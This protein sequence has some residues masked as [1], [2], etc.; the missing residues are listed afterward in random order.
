M[1]NL[2]NV[3]DYLPESYKENILSNLKINY[4]HGP[5]DLSHMSY[6][7]FDDPP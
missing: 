2:N 6:Y 5:I 1:P 4:D 7:N 3:I